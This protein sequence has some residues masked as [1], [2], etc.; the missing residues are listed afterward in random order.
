MKLFPRRVLNFL[1]IEKLRYELSC[2]LP[3]ISGLPKIIVLFSFYEKLFLTKDENIINAFAPEFIEEYLSALNHYS[4]FYSE[5]RRTEKRLKQL[6]ELKLI[7]VLENNHNRIDELITSINEKLNNLL[8]LLEGNSVQVEKRKK[9]LFPLLGKVVTS[10]ETYTYSSIESVTIKVTPAKHKDSFVFVPSHQKKEQLEEQAK[11]SFQLALQYLK[12]YKGKFH[13]YHE[14]LIYFDNISAEYD[15]SSLG[16]ALTI[17]FI[18]QLSVLY[19]LPH[20]AIVK[21]NIASTGGLDKNGNV[22]ALG[23]EIIKNKVEATFYS[24]LETLIIPEADEFAAKEKLKE[25]K[26]KYP[27]RKFNFVPVESLTDLLNRRNLIEIK[28]Q[29]PLVRIV[30]NIKKNGGAVS[31]SLIILL[32]IGFIWIRDFDD[33]P[34]LLDSKK[35][36][37]YVKNKYGRILWTRE[38]EYLTTDSGEIMNAHTVQKLVDIDSDGKNEPI[39]AGN[40]G[41]NNAKI[42]ALNYKGN[43]IWSYICNDTVISKRE[44]LV[45]PY[46]YRILDTLTI[47]G[48]KQLICFVCNQNSFSSAIFKLDLKTGKRLDGTLWNSGFVVEGFIVDIDKDGNKEIVFSVCNNGYEKAGLVVINFCELNGTKVLP[49][50][51]SYTIRNFPQIK[52]KSY[53]LFPNSDYNRHLNLRWT[54]LIAGNLRN[55]PD[56][57]TISIWNFQKQ[58]SDAVLYQIKYDLK[59]ISVYIGD[60]FSQDRDPLVRNGKLSYPLTDTKKYRN[61]LK[62][63]ILFWNGNKF[64]KREEL[65]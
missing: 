52:I 35:N 28:K 39:I 8:I 43:E 19:N 16:I 44:L 2:F 11:I 34:A 60:D 12:E 37:L 33:N 58:T 9:F 38:M 24:D 21:N 41:T 30:K 3:R 55:H 50:V 61:F 40:T 47:K 49:S 29:S 1:Y 10:S 25:L 27:N 13:K 64:V 36:I 23:E 17:G 22:S 51:P 57:K 59:N 20:L 7:P 14:V 42:T 56:Q 54:S 6:S 46:S 31:L 63:Q 65:E 4:P 5:P 62:E 26:E 48:Q 45:P 15:G 32:I 53:I 18:E